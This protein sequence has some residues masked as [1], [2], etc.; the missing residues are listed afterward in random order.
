MP[1]QVIVTTTINP[2]TEAIKKFDA[3]PDWHLVVAGD[4][5]T[6]KDYRLERGAYLSPDDQ[7]S[8]DHLLST[9]VGWNCMQR[10]NLAILAAYDLGAEV[11]AVVDD[12]N[13]PL[14]GWGQDLM[15]ERAVSAQFYSPAVEVF[16]PVGMA[17]NFQLWHRGFPLQLLQKRT[18]FASSRVVIRPIQADFWNGDPDI[19]AICR[20]EHAPDC[21]FDPAY[22]P[23]A[24]DAFS[25]FNSQNTFIARRVISDYFLFPDIGRMDDIWASY[26][27][28]SRGHFPVYGKASVY[29]QRNEHN[30]THDM[31]Q[32]FLG[33]EH[34]LQLVQDLKKA[35][36]NLFLYLPSRSAQ[37]HRLYRRHFSNA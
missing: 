18:R 36:K 5:R 33:Y 32:E 2:P 34:N 29:Q 4:L 17:T 24:S 31:Q 23:M 37:V 19:D 9:A 21:V 35:S 10:R 22:F 30:P 15:V 28:E 1:S 3:M 27:A 7:D 6:P 14:P 11:I 8:Y 13:I 16:D 12:D 20:M 25:P 26:Y